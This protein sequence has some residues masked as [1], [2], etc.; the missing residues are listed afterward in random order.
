MNLLESLLEAL[1]DK[2]K[3]LVDHFRKIANYIPDQA[4]TELFDKYAHKNPH[5][6]VL[7]LEKPK[8]FADSTVQKHL[9]KNGWFVHNYTAGLAG[10]YVND[11]NGEKKL[12]LKSI[13]KVLSET[14][15]DKIK[16][17]EMLDRLVKGSNGKPIKDENDRFVSEKVPQSILH[18]YNNDKNRASANHQ[19]NMVISRDTNDIGGMTSGRSWESASCMRL[20]HSSNDDPN[21]QHAGQYHHLIEGDLKHHSLVVYATKK[22]DDDIEKPLARSLLKKY[23]SDS[24]HVIYRPDASDVYGNAPKGFKEAISKFAEDH[25]PAHKNV[26]YNLEDDLYNDTGRHHIMN[27][28]KSK[29]VK[30]DNKVVNY[31]KNG[32]LHDYV[33]EHGNH[34]PAVV[35]TAPDSTHFKHFKNGVLHNENGPA[36]SST[37]SDGSFSKTYQID[38]TLHNPN[39]PASET[40]M[41]NGDFLVSHNI[42]GMLHREGDLPA[43]HKKDAAGTLKEYRTYGML[44]REGDKPAFIKRTKIAHEIGYYKFGELNRDGNKPTR[45]V[46]NFDNN[47]NIKSKLTETHQNGFL[48]STD[49]KPSS[50]EDSDGIITKKWHKNGLLH[51]DNDKPSFV[52]YDKKT[53]K[54]INS[55]WHKNGNEERADGKPFQV[56]GNLK[57]F[58]LADGSNHYQYDVDGHKEHIWL[59]GHDISEHKPNEIIS[60]NNT[61]YSMARGFGPRNVKIYMMKDAHGNVHLNNSS[62]MKSV[63]P[64]ITPDGK[65]KATIQ[66]GEIRDLDELEKTPDNDGI[67][68]SIKELLKHHLERGATD[69][70]V[71]E[72]FKK[73]LD[74]VKSQL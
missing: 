62:M 23:K 41:A 24:G 22:G 63:H 14:G 32:N 44:N 25:W 64:V 46:V 31:N 9:A 48:H 51:R 70:Y 35:E 5:H 53:K 52:A 67:T 59:R 4:H 43:Y 42:D 68:K 11:I 66:G 50:I 16:H 72:H 69:P 1:N 45:T 60:G 19:V 13:G 61:E 56:T 17:H 54:I 26:G 27:I 12:Q 18:F 39:G 73:Q 65:I 29:L 7:P 55:I 28:D 37:Y 2:Q 36:S 57:S 38:G 6:I 58:R 74:R 8:I 71:G 33:D 49:D 21:C 15:A 30:T 47:G 10:R 20:P 34:Q 40:R 3:Y